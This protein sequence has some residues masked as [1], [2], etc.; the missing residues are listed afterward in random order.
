[1]DH[2]GIRV[3]I[4][5]F[6]QQLAGKILF[7]KI[8]PE[9]T[10]VAFGRPVAT[11]ES[12]KWVGRVAS[13]V[14][15]TITEVNAELE[16]NPGLINESPYDKGWLVKIKPENLSKDLTKLLTGDEAM[17][18]LKREIEKSKIKKR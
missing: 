17:K 8:R 4:T 15:G 18:A 10:R 7:V 13:P 5:D 14:T 16:S 2:D 11:I 9:G 3:G 1:V 6:G 12:A